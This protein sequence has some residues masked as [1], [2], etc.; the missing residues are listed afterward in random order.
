[1]G[2]RAAMLLLLLGPTDTW[3]TL[4]G[5]PG[6]ASQVLELE[7]AGAVGSA[8]SQRPTAHLRCPSP[9][10]PDPDSS[11]T[12][13]HHTTTRQRPSLP[14]R[15]QHRHPATR[16]SPPQAEQPVLISQPPQRSIHRQPRRALAWSQALTELTSGPWEWVSSC[17]N[18]NTSRH[19]RST[20]AFD[21]HPHL[22]PP[23]PSTQP[24]AFA[25]RHAAEVC[26]A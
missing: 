2:A 20:T 24:W 9:P 25:T 13:R 21:L 17:I 19:R 18:K 3:T 10:D 5:D 16:C 6:Q 7:A 12:P 23:R 4:G 11:T 15:L 22:S 8:A 1:M 14:P 26:P